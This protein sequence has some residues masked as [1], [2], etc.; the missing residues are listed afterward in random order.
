MKNLLV[1]A[2]LALAVF[3]QAQAGEISMADLDH[4]QP[5]DVYVLGE[6]HDNPIHHRGQARLIRAVQP[7]AVVFEMLTPEQAGQITP[8]LLR[9]EDALEA[10]L[11]WNAS[12][13]PDFSIYYPIF[14]ALGE[15]KIFGAALAK[16]EVRRAYFEGA[17]VVFGDRAEVFGLDQPLPENQLQ[18]RKQMQFEA[19]CQA[20]PLE[21]MAGMVEAQRIRDAAFAD[22]VLK[23]FDQTGG[24]VV[25][26]AGAGH[27]H[28][29]W[30]VPALL[31]QAKSPFSIISIAF[32]EAPAEPDRKFD[33]WVETAPAER[34]DP[35]LALQK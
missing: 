23:A 19:H 34:E 29:D 5:A 3:G 11:G 31:K 28:Y 24:P 7:K 35:C 16:N 1:S 15:A 17:A 21:M 18:Q 2:T 26:I 4:L 25:L 30:A 13:W 12:G 9:D 27:A 14:A 8:E 22:A 32:L 20:M 10:A 33:F 6:T